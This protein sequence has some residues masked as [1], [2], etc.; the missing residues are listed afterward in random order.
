MDIR[1]YQ[2]STN[3]LIPKLPFLRVV[4]EIACDFKSD[5]RLTPSAVLALHEASESYLVG[6]FEDA[7][8][9]ALHCKRVTLMK[10]DMLLA[11]CIRGEDKH[12]C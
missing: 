11:R 9:C 7:N 4:K 12:R 8:L 10:K 3:L 6:L 5:V 1:K 2:A